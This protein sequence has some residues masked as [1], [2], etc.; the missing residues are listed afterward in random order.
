MITGIHIFTNMDA[1]KG[2]IGV[3]KVALVIKR[4]LMMLKTINL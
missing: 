4:A 2:G 1:H 3:L